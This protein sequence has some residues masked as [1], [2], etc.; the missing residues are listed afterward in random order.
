VGYLN[1][2]GFIFEFDLPEGSARAHSLTA[3][4]KGPSLWAAIEK[5]GGDALATIQPGG[6]I[7][8]HALPSPNHKLGALH[9]DRAGLLWMGYHSPDKLAMARVGEKNT[10]SIKEF[11]LSDFRARVSR[12]TLGPEGNLWFI[13]SG[14]DKVGFV[15]D[16][17][18][19]SK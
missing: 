19:Y 9:F 12:M 2:D 18:T 15:I 16:T 3:D 1:T 17:G 10:L 11:P 7:S 8:I 13:Q 14:T 6:E 4:P 5:P